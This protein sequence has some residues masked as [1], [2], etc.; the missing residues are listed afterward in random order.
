ML[1]RFFVP[2]LFLLTSSLSASELGQTQ[3]HSSLRGKVVDNESRGLSSVR[4]SIATASPKQGS[5]Y[6]CPSCY[7][8]CGKMAMTDATGRFE[9]PNLDPELRFELLL[10]AD[11]YVSAFH[12][13]ID[14]AEDKPVMALQPFDS[15]QIAPNQLFRGSDRQRHH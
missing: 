10:V 3:P 12:P 13:N 1:G 2:C 5:G 7:V 14:P 15:T 9:I 8:D 11:G 4:V 6:L